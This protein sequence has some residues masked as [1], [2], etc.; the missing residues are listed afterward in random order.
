MGVGNALGQIL[1]VTLLG[2][3]QS[4]LGWPSIFVC[5]AIIDVF[6]IV[7]FFFL[8]SDKQVV[9]QSHVDQNDSQSMFEKIVKS[10]QKLEFLFAFLYAMSFGMASYGSAGTLFTFINEEV[11]ENEFSVLEDTVLASLMAL[12]NL[13]GVFLTRFSVPRLGNRNSGLFSSIYLAIC[14]LLLISLSAGS[15]LVHISVVYFFLGTGW[16]MRTMVLNII[17][18][19]FADPNVA[20]FT[21]SLLMAGANLGISLGDWFCGMFVDNF[22]FRP[23]FGYVASINGISFILVFIMYYLKAR[24]TIQV[25]N[26]QGDTIVVN[27]EEQIEEEIGTSLFDEEN[28]QQKVKLEEDE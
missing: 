4:E 23:T 10:F 1:V 27:K 17:S 9:A 3:L 5:L 8:P 2:I 14:T 12:G 24:K 6:P 7:S 13:C 19:D 20:A 28:Q 26:I 11:K 18:M 16:G 22:D 15:S 21:Y 25:K